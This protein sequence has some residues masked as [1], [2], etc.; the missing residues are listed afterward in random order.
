LRCVK[1]LCLA[2]SQGKLTTQQTEAGKPT[3][4]AVPQ[5]TLEIKGYK[6]TWI[7]KSDNKRT[8]WVHYKC[9]DKK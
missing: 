6:M 4:A 5:E 1:D 9:G 3:E 2:I 7:A 8:E